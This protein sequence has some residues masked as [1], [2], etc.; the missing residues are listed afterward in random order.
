MQNVVIR[1]MMPADA[2]V[3]GYVHWKSCLETYK[4]LL[5]PAYFENAPLAAYQAI[6]RRFPD[7]T[8]VAEIGGRIV[9]FGT[10]KDSGEVY[11]LYVLQEFQGCGIG[12]MLL[13]ALLE[14]LSPRPHI[15]LMVLDGNDHA[16]GFY[17]HMGFRLDGYRERNN[18]SAVH[19]SLRMVRTV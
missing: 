15:W 5:D 2:D 4:G 1:P 18:Y 10:W 13:E 8:L 12:R 19:P 16:I 17:E 11:G 9:G 7:K 6:A 14:Q 3:K